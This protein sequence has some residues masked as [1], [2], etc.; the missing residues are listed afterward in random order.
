MIFLFIVTLMVTLAVVPLPG[1]T[2]FTVVAGDRKLVEVSDWFQG[3]TVAE[4]LDV[5]AYL[6]TRKPPLNAVIS[7]PP[8]TIYPHIVDGKRCIVSNFIFGL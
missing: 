4:N 8:K 1:T 6:Y 2:N 7:L 5:D 3:V